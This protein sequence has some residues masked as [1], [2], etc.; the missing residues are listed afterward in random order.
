MQP[1]HNIE[2]PYCGET[3]QILIDDSVEHQRYIEDCWVC[4]RPIDVEVTVAP[5]DE[6]DIVVRTESDV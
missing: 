1:A 2:C 4:C 6:A 5:D 3:I